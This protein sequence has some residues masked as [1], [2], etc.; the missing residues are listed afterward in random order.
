[1]FD[2]LTFGD[3]LVITQALMA[4]TGVLGYYLGHRGFKG[5]VSDLNNVKTDVENIKARIF[6]VQTAT[7]VIVTPVQTTP[8]PVA[9]TAHTTVVP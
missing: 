8:T 5:V 1:M 3:N 4:V 9:T 2:F 7:P 6:P